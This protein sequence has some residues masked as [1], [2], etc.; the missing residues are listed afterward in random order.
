MTLE[1]APGGAAEGFCRDCLCLAEPADVRCPAC[2]SPRLLRHPELHS[3]AIAHLDCDA[4]YAAVEKRDDASL[5]DQPVIIGGGR[6]GVVATACYVARVSGVRSAM[7]MF[8]ALKLCPEAVVIAPNMRKYSAVGREVRRL[9]LAVTPL[10]EPLSIDEAFLDLSGTARLHR[11]KPRRFPC[12]PGEQDRGRGRHLRLH[13]SFLQQVSCQGR[14]RSRQ[15]AWLFTD[16][17]DRGGRI[18]CR[19]A[20]VADLGSRKGPASFAGALGHHDDGPASEHGKGGL[21]CRFG[22]MGPRPVTSRGAKTTAGFHPVMKRRASA[23][24]RPSITISTS[25]RSSSASFGGWP[26]GFPSAPRTPGSLARLWYSSSRQR[27]SNCAPAT[28]RSPTRPSSPLRIF[29]AARALLEGGRRHSVSAH[30]RQHHGS[31]GEDLR[32]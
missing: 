31:C 3:L 22:A 15:A 25:C 16:R 8:K 24:R 7:P 5:K 6:R 30:R 9:M 17:P 12:P 13:R 32:R 2:R 1:P 23:R 4:F 14:F 10:V 11:R 27:S 29:S 21:V 28:V 18:P 20:G 26:R 19:P